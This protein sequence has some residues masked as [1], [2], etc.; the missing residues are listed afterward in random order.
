MGSVKNGNRGLARCLFFW[1][2]LVFGLVQWSFLPVLIQTDVQQGSLSL[3]AQTCHTA[4]FAAPF[5]YIFS[6]SLTACLVTVS[7]E[8][9]QPSESAFQFPQY[10]S[11]IIH[12]QSVTERQL[13]SPPSA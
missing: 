9:P 5:K 2:V 3:E 1:A 8:V 4:K 7:V 11:A 13:R 6:D 12:E 10:P